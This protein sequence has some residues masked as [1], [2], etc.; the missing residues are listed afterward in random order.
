MPSP[1][2]SEQHVLGVRSAGVAHV[3]QTRARHR[4]TFLLE[5]AAPRRPRGAEATRQ[6]VSL[7]RLQVL[8]QL[9]LLC[10]R[11]L[12]F[13][14]VVVVVDDRLEGREPAVVVEAALV[15]LLGIE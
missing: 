8:D 1:K 3:E 15:D 10:G 11:Q 14:V 9:T 13:Q 7:N 4:I 12:E 6:P 5:A 2:T